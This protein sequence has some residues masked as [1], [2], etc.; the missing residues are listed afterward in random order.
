[1]NVLLDDLKTAR[2]SFDSHED[3]LGFARQDVK[4][5]NDWLAIHNLNVVERYKH[6][7]IELVL[8]LSIGSEGSDL[9]LIFSSVPDVRIRHTEPSF[10]PEVY[11][12]SYDS[13]SDWNDRFMLVRDCYSVYGPEDV[14]PSQV[15]LEPAKERLDLFRDILTPSQAVT[16]F[17]EGSSE[18]ESSVQGI[19]NA[20]G[21]GNRVSR[22][23][24]AVSE[25]V[26]SISSQK[27]NSGGI[28]RTNFIL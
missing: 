6:S 12:S 22:S 15:R 14:I 3:V 23:I 18:G 10:G 17:V 5:F 4:R 25:I 28:G 1:M 13:G 27:E 20:R 7:E 24:K 19:G 26:S 16:H 21:N 2:L 11:A 8:S 9:H